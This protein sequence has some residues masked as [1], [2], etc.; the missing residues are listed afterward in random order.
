MDYVIEYLNKTMSTIVRQK[1][2]K[3]KDRSDKSFLPATLQAADE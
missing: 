3:I 1:K 2:I